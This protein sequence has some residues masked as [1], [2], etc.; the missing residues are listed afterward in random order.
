MAVPV[1]STAGVL[2]GAAIG[3]AAGA[4]LDAA[5]VFSKG[6]ARQI[7]EAIQSVLGKAA[8]TEQNRRDVGDYCE[9]CKARGIRGTKNDRGD[10]TFQELK[11]RVREFFGTDG[12]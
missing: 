5:I 2:K 4:A 1:L 8:N 9:D 3:G 11:Q 6:E 10:F 12:T 7:G